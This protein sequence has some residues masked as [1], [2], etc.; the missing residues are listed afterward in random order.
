M[1]IG[2]DF[3][4]TIVCYDAIFHRVASERGL[5]PANLPV[6]KSAVRDHLRRI[7]REDDWTEMQGYVYGPRLKD[8]EAYPG[9][10]EFFTLAVR[11]GVPIRVI[12][13]KTLHPFRGEKH[14]LHAAALGWLELNGFF[15]PARI[16]MPRDQVYLELTKES[17]HRRIALSGCTHFVDDLPEFLL[18]PGFPAGVRRF[19][20][21]PHAQG[22]SSAGLTPLASWAA[23]K[24]ALLQEVPAP[25]AAFARQCLSSAEVKVQRLE[26]GANNR[27]YR[28][29][30]AG[31]S[32]VIKAYHR[33]AADQ[34]DRFAAEKAFYQLLDAAHPGQSARPLGWDEENR[35]GAF[36]ELPGVKLTPEA[37]TD[38]HVQQAAHW[39][40]R[41][42][43][44]RTHDLAGSVKPA[45]EACFSTEEHLATLERRIGRLEAA[46]G[47]ATD[48]EFVRFVKEA[49]APQGRAVMQAVRE[50]GAPEASAPL[51]AGERIL[52]PSDF[53]FHNALLAEDG[54]LRFF[55]FEYAGWDDPA[56]LACDFICQPRIPVTLA[57]GQLFAELLALQTGIASLP[58]RVSLLLPVY[59]VKWTCIML[60]EFLADGAARRDFAAAGA[61]ALES[62][63]RQLA[64]ARSL[65]ESLSSAPPPAF[66]TL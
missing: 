66:Q 26:G 25:V 49:L 8:A 33:A 45:S 56:K 55:D 34:R 31:G 2:V 11:L 21:D 60:N 28:A 39:I 42:Q 40:A 51:P 57:Q 7:D 38:A 50:S 58:A 17:K 59:M 16:G 52:S 41:L 13:H 27:V 3:D 14:D 54:I 1:I 29:S 23:L 44:S 63:A 35:L 61:A 65:L 19:L 62:R 20:F 18:D 15:D 46:A 12:S 47:H 43:D 9:V 32:V 37:I 5:I 64:K 6:S 30:A 10:L 36:T 24:E 53:G 48:L 22:S 4:N